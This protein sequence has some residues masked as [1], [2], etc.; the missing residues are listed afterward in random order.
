MSN[1]PVGSWRLVAHTGSLLFNTVV[2]LVFM[3]RFYYQY[4]SLRRKYR[5]MENPCNYTVM[6]REIPLKK[7]KEHSLFQHFSKLFPNQVAS[8]KLIPDAPKLLDLKQER[9][10]V[11]MNLERAQAIVLK[12]EERP[13]VR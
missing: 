3:F 8:V 9:L 5:R 6:V 7:R 4:I 10:V 12:T 2:T 13:V 11:V 1:V